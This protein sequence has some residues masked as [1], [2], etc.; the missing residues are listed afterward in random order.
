MRT[1]SG[2]AMMVLLACA[3]CATS[4]AQE[5]QTAPVADFVQYVLEQG[6]VVEGRLLVDLRKAPVDGRLVPVEVTRVL[7]GTVEADT[8][9][10]LNLIGGSR[11]GGGPRRGTKIIGWGGE[12]AKGITGTFAVV[13]PRGDITVS[14]IHISGTPDP[15][16]VVA[17]R[18]IAEP[19]TLDRFHDEVARLR[20]RNVAE[21]LYSGDA[22]ALVRVS[23]ANGRDLSV[24]F[25]SWLA[26]KAEHA[27]NVVR[28]VPPSGRA[29]LPGAG[30]QFLIPVPASPTDTLVA[31]LDRMSSCSPERADGWVGAVGVKLSELDRAGWHDS[32]GMHL[33]PI[34]RGGPRRR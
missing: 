17:G 34:R 1:L 25:V 21:W 9:A 20:G 30:A 31:P 24:Q 16:F 14:C 4:R 5:A 6:F 2:L 29:L 19:R 22:I 13:G 12:A 15:V 8:L 7:A 23:A 3:F 33:K 26:G 10:L 11:S 18:P 28:M 32:A 27:P